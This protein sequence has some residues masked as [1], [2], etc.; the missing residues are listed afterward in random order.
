M[1]GLT[2]KVSVV[3]VHLVVK[4]RIF[5]RITE[6]FITFI[7]CSLSRSHQMYE[8]TRVGTNYSAINLYP[9]IW[10]FNSMNFKQEIHK[11]NRSFTC[12]LVGYKNVFTFILYTDLKALNLYFELYKPY[13]LCRSKNE[14]GD[15]NFPTVHSDIIKC[16]VLFKQSHQDTFIE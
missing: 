14:G 15:S 6:Y 11:Q 13:F 7:R 2:A 12:C 16:L 9:C 1:Q 4:H 3:S 8:S 10:T 5:K